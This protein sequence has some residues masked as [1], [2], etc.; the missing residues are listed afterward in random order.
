MP[1]S[2]PLVRSFTR[3][4]WRAASSSPTIYS[5]AGPAF[6]R[7]GGTACQSQPR[8]QGILCANTRRA[9]SS[10]RSQPQGAGLPSPEND[11]D[12]GLLYHLRQ[13]AAL[14]EKTGS[15]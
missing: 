12:I 15:S 4:W 3:I 14:F 5:K 1:T 6:D 2:P 10:R 13:A 8:A 9:Q 11:K 7:L